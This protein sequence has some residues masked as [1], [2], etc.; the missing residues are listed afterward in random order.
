M[1]PTRANANWRWRSNRVLV[2][3]LSAFQLGCGTPLLCARHLRLAQI[4]MCIIT[5]T[6]FVF[7]PTEAAQPDYRVPWLRGIQAIT[8]S[9][10]PIVDGSGMI[11]SSPCRLDR[12]AFEHHGVE[13]LDQAGLNAIGAVD[14]FEKLRAL[15]SEFNQA[16]HHLEETPPGVKPSW[17]REQS[18]SR[19]KEGD[20]LAYQPVLFVHIGVATLNG[21]LCAA[22]ITTELRAFSRDRPIIN[23][24]GEQVMAALALWD[25]PPLTLA[26]SSAEFEHAVSERWGTQVD[27]FI[28]A[29]RT[30]N[31]Q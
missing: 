6:V 20:F 17:N 29:W 27:A 26:T 11:S 4:F 3:K 18:E 10:N 19:R 28:T 13:M 25:A 31:G 15:Q 12:I 16:L 2:A 23:Y 21:G 9:V 7:H 14:K 8:I 30:A 1:T 5:A 22:G 24:N